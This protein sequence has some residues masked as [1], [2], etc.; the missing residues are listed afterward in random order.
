MRVLG[1]RV[2]TRNGTK[3]SSLP[4]LEDQDPQTV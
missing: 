3:R 4:C 1:R 2:M